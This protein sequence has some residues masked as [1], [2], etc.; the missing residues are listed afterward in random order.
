MNFINWQQFGLVKNPYDT[1]PLV[2]GG[3]VPIEK[4]FIGRE[5]EQK[6]LSDLFENEDNL[7][8]T[9]CGDVGVGK[10]SLTNFQKVIWKYR[11][12]KLLFSFRREIEASA[13]LLNK[14]NFLLEIIGSILREIELLDESLLGN[15]FLKR[16][17]QLVDITQYAD[18]SGGI[19]VN[20]FGLN[21]SHNQNIVFP[22]TFSLAMLEK[23]FFSLIEFLLSHKVN[24]RKYS[25]LIIHVNNFDTVLLDKTQKKKVI[26]FFNE[27][28]DILQI[29]HVYCLFLGP[30]NFFKD[31]ISSQKRVKGIF[32]QTPLQI[33]PLSKN[34]L[35]RA[36]DE[37]MRLLR[38]PSVANYI[39]PIED[40]VIYRLYDLY[41]GDIRL[42]M[43]SIKDLLGQYSDRVTQPLSVDEAMLLLGKERL[44]RLEIIGLTDEQ[45][46]V[47]GLFIENKEV[48]QKDVSSFLG[49]AQSNVSGYYFNPLREG[50]VIEEKKSRRKG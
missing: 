1:A 41:N 7:N 8:L 35:V 39:K 50:E 34:E 31:I 40:K 49:K 18:I 30:K 22:P 17:H 24:N 44:S 38:S 2:E 29:P 4:A 23:Y 33:K 20:G 9:I 43:S 32:A 25:G 45:K 6:F 16:L 10:T 28:R 15:H 36:F 42:I 12:P 21:A 14:E 46:K 47:L 26:Q 11:T 19:S 27:I 48:S 3:D 13:S 37:R 5:I